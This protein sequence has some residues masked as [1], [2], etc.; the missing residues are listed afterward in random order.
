GVGQTRTELAGLRDSYDEAALAV[1]VALQL[2]AIG[3]VA[4]WSRLGIYRVLSQLTGEDLRGTSVHPG[5]ERLLDDPM[6]PPLLQTLETY[7][8]LA[9]SASATAQQMNLHRTSLYY[10][11][12]RVEELAHTS[13]KDGNE[14]L[15]L[16][17]AL[18][19]ARLTGRH[20][21]GGEALGAVGHSWTA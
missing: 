17:L 9:G 20:H 10:R 21:P 2:P 18:K 13:L 5:L 6:H 8:E 12:Q 14:R 4:R 3:P 15:S 19:V 1:R 7:L 16:H 11:L